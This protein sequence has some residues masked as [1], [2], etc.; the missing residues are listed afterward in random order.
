MEQNHIHTSPEAAT[1][2]PAF[3]STLMTRAADA[4]APAPPEP[5]SRRHRHDGWIPER[6]VAFLEALAACGVVAEACKQVGL[7]AQSA[8]AFRNRRSGRAFGTAWDAVLIHRARGRLSDEVMSR[9]MNGC[10]QTV[11]EDGEIKAERHRFDNRLAMAVLTRLDRLAEREGDRDEQLRAISEDLDDFLDCVE[12]GG[13]ADAFVEARRPPPEPEP[14]EKGER[15]M[16]SQSEP[17][18][19]D[20][21]GRRWTHFPP[22]AG[23]DGEEVGHYD[24]IGFYARTLSAAEEEVIERE[25]AELRAQEAEERDRYFD[26][27]GNGIGSSP[28]QGEA[29][30]DASCAAAACRPGAGSPNPSTSSTYRGEG[31]KGDG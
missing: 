17:V 18:W 7:S 29:A 5:R 9:A 24:A 27:A 4:A 14:E 26:F 16:G 31:G 28:A 22:P 19:T 12:E 15:R 13:D 20:E 23:F 3:P 6:Q 1:D 10:V 25:L 8:Y 11:R 21:D 2:E 30:P